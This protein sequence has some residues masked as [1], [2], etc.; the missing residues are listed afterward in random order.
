MTSAVTTRLNTWRHSL[1][2]EPLDAWF[3]GLRIAALGAGIVWWAV[4]AASATTRV[5]PASPQ[6][7]TLAAF[8]AFTVALYVTNTLAP[9]HIALLYR[10]ALV[11]DLFIVFGLV[12][13]TERYASD[14]YL[15]FVLLIALHAFYF[16]ISTGILAAVAAGAVYALAVDWPPPV[17]GFPLRVAFFGLVGVCMGGLAEQAHRRQV[18]LEHQQE[19]LLRSDRLATVGEMAVGLAHEL[20]NPLAGMAG[21]LHVL[22]DQLDRDDD[23][24]SLFADVQS[25]IVR[26]NNTLSD[27]LQ[28]ARPAT[29]QRIAV[30]INDLVE[31]SLR[32]IPRDA[33]EVVRRYDRALPS[34][35]VDTTLIHQA[36]LNMLVNAHQAMPHGGRLTVVTRLGA[37]REL[38]VE[39][40]IDDTGSGI[41][42]EHLRRVFQ[43]FFTTKAQGTGLGLAIAAR[44]VEQHGGRISVESKIGAG[45]TFTVALPPAPPPSRRSESDGSPNPRR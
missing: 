27:L 38:P 35:W 17:P 29:P 39:V 44:I 42:P 43:P 33:V 41:E 19:Q 34:V 22:E 45:S 1:R 11:F 21:A 20:R 16:G 7:R 30:D 26:M 24:H 12:R 3:L 2:L 10:V 25:Q 15:A 8:F 5:S 36:L 9:G 37:R 13:V 14:L 23:R 4:G 31:Q 40:S 28:H 18:V 6:L 32:F